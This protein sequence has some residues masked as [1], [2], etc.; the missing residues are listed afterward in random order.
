MYF[1]DKIES[2][3]STH[4]PKWFVFLRVLLG[5]CLFVK[6]VSFMGNAMLLQQIIDESSSLNNF[7]W[8]PQVITWAHLLGGFLI[9]VGLFIRLACLL[10]IPI[11]LGAIIFVHVKNGFISFNTDLIFSIF[12]LLL[13]IVFFI[14]GGGKISLDQYFKTARAPG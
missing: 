1:M 10:Q 3:S 6:G 4:H 13:L 11:L 9:V 7:T 12:I 5:L 14:E 2:W 8:L